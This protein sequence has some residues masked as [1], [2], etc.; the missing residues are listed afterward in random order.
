MKRKKI[1]ALL[2][3]SLM[4]LSLASCGKDEENTPVAGTKTSSAAGNGGK[5]SSADYESYPEM[6]D[7]MDDINSGLTNHDDAY[8][9][10]LRDIWKS[11]PEQGYVWTIT[12]NDMERIQGANLVAVETY[13]GLSMSHVGVDPYGVYRGAMGVSNWIDISGVNTLLALIP[14]TAGGFEMSDDTLWVRDDDLV[15]AFYPCDEE[16]TASVEKAYD[17]SDHSE[18]NYKKYAEVEDQ[19]IY[20]DWTDN[21][22]EEEKP[23][24]D[25]EQQLMDQYVNSKITQ[26]NS[27]IKDFEKPENL[28][29]IGCDWKFNKTSGSDGLIVDT[30]IFVVTPLG[31][32]HMIGRSSVYGN[33]VEN[34]RSSQS[35]YDTGGGPMGLLMDLI[36]GE[37]RHV[38]TETEFV[39]EE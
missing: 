15:M 16:F 35:A 7:L 5:A 25:T 13:V 12:I 22:K 1:F 21:K 4:M 14:Y 34:M 6:P 37:A 8:Y 18:Q 20:Y 28:S 23:L 9:E 10:T 24:T 3:A 2:L 39:D 38:E 27:E 31:G 19:N 17:E 32:T 11:E 29:A 30:D 33:H 36:D 26:K